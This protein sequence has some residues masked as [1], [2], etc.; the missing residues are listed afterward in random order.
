MTKICSTVVML[1][2]L[3]GCSWFNKEC[4]GPD[5]Q[6]VR[7]MLDT[8]ASKKTWYCYGK[9]NGGWDCQDHKSPDKITVVPPATPGAVESPGQSTDDVSDDREIPLTRRSDRIGADKDST[10][11]VVGDV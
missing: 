3:A 7:T 9:P 6:D 2:L 11:N 5:C 10:R 4:T 1:V 8:S